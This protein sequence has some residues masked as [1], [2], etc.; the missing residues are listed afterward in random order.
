MPRYSKTAASN[1]ILLYVDVVIPKLRPMLT[2]VSRLSRAEAPWN[3][4]AVA[5]NDLNIVP[6]ATVI[7]LRFRVF[8]N[9]VP[10]YASKTSTDFGICS[11]CKTKQSVKLAY[12]PPITFVKPFGIVKFLRL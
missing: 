7:K 10:A 4:I 6:A 8:P 1:V 12:E 3:G 5:E 11:A 9:G 2:I